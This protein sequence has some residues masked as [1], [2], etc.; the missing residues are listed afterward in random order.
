[1]QV[2]VE[3]GEGLERRLTVELP[4]EKIDA[5]VTKRLQQIGRTA[6]LDGF[7]PGKVPMKLLRRNYGG[8]VLQEV[9]GQMIESSYQE[10]IQ[11]EK[12]QPA[13]MPKI[14]PGESSE[15]DGLFRYVATVEVMPEI[16]L[17]PL[18]GEVKRPV[19]EI[20]DQ[21]VD[22]MLLKLRKQRVT[23]SSVERD[24]A[25][26][27]QV[28]ISFKGTIDGEA[29]EGGSAENVDLVLG[30]GRMIEGFESALI[31][32]SKGDKSS[33][34]LKFP[35]NYRVEELADKPVTFEVE[36]NDISEEVLPEIDDEF[37]KEFGAEEGVDKLMSDVRENMTRE[38]AQRIEAR[39]KN[40]AMDLLTEQN[41]IDVPSAMVD[42]EIEALQNQTRQQMAQGAGSFELPRE[43][44]EDQAKKRVTLGL[45]I[46]EIIKQ[47]DIQVDND[48]VKKRIEEFAASYEKPEEVV[49]YYY[50][51]EKQ[52]ATVQN[53]VMEDQV[54]DWVLEQV[55][56]TEEQ[57]TFAEL[58]EQG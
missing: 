34:D 48:R 41:P 24:A 21:D 50:S 4:A 1:M 29:F 17:N 52:L 36:I 15:D 55:T 53:V 12:L 22:E 27:D 26:G 7:R 25:E 46:G 33:I 44:F 40:Q 37:A 45:L 20:A 19:A 39:I 42:Q 43:M 2:S 49:N 57:T 51:D 58:T 3:S 28:K 13:G 14:E 56:I 6:K 11:Q 10:A 54:V 31:G 32:K 30:S 38:L 47:N 23:W 5:E 16:T 18:S 8:Q 9:Y 35:E